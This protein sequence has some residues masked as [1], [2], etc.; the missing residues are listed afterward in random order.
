MRRI[1]AI[2]L[3]LFAGIA[4]NAQNYPSD[5]VRYTSDGYFHDIESGQNKQDALDLAR[6][7][8]ARQIQVRVQEA[9]RIDKE[10]IN[11]RTNILYS[12]QK[13]FSTDVDMNLSESKS[14]F[15][16]TSGKHFVI[17]YINKVEACNYYENDVKMFVSKVNNAIAIA[18]N[19]I[20]TG[21][22]S[23]AKEEL[24]NALKMF[25]DVAKSFF[26]LN[27][28]GMEEYQM[29][30]YLDKVNQLEQT[31]KA[32][33]AELEYGTTYCVVCNA[34]CFGRNYPK[35]KNEIKGELSALGCN[36][37]DTPDNADYVIYVDASAR[38]YNTM[39]NAGGSAYFSYVDAAV[40]V[41]KK[42]TGQRIFEDEISVK[43]SHTI[44]YNEAARD[45]YK[46]ISKEISKLLK[47]N[48][49]L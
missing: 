10:A 37:V 19:Y 20:N 32:K 14:H 28:F 39:N 16:Q 33:I 13:N 40:A 21:F 45:G 11:G 8:L 29:Q 48:I 30:H 2:T 38:E 44:S 22:K 26:W 3:L 18:D 47:E 4:L 23:K 15:D 1:L 49:K 46:Q 35:L 27:I 5:W 6:S 12:S 25:D 43:G 41:D 17:V 9:S 31:V 36:F 24:Q 34:D 42:A 7:N